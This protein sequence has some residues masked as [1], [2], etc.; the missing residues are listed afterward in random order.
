MDKLDLFCCNGASSARDREPHQR[1]LLAN[2]PT[3]F[4]NVSRT[5][6]GLDYC[7]VIDAPTGYHAPATHH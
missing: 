2:G 5:R 7:A 3:Y 1:S 4:C 6:L